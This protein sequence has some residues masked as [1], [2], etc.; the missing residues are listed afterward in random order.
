MR[1]GA[2][3]L[4]DKTRPPLESARRNRPTKTNGGF[5]KEVGSHADETRQVTWGGT[6]GVRR[7]ASYD[8]PPA[9]QA[10]GAPQHR[11]GKIPGTSPLVSR[12]QEERAEF[13]LLMTTPRISLTIDGRRRALGKSEPGFTSAGSRWSGFTFERVQLPTVKRAATCCWPTTHVEMI[14]EGCV[15]TRFRTDNA[16][17]S[18]SATPT[19]ISIWPQ[20]YRVAE[21]RCS[22]SA[23][24][25]VV[26]LERSL[27]HTF[28]QR[29]SDIVWTTLT[30]R[31]AIRDP[32]I[33]ALLMAIEAEIKGGCPGGDLFDESLSAALAA[34]LVKRYSGRAYNPRPK[35]PPFLGKRL[36][37][38]LDYIA[39]NVS[40]DLSLDVLAGV[41]NM[42]P[43]YFCRMFK[44]STGLTPHQYVLA[45][46]I[47]RAK[48]ILAED[49]ATIAEVALRFGFASQ[50]HFTSVFHRHTGTTP[51]RYQRIA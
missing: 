38:V 34:Y 37:R 36:Q 9:H 27:L 35:R 49:E 2:P 25:L 39:A 30:P 13:E 29:H 31:F 40:H 17:H 28:V 3:Q 20:D 4:A 7:C 51:R 18:F 21:L 15:H 46:R 19:S 22:G 43:H 47:N 44:V 23:Q 24:A 42:S 8:P 41:A 48:Q 1:S 10:A 50:S 11:Q 12:P 32:Q 14:I 45:E 26:S 6:T 33:I 5:W 16:L